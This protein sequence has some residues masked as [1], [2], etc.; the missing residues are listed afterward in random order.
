MIRKD[1]H[2]LWFISQNNTVRCCIGGDQHKMLMHHTDPRL[3]GFHGAGKR[4]LFSFVP[5]GAAGSLL[6]SKD[7]FHQGRLPRTVLTYN[8]MNFSLP[9]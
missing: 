3:N 1:L 7:N 2:F 9:E 5:H 6:D 8:R 4:N